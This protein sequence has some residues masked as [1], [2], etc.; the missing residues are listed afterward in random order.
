SGTEVKGFPTGAGPNGEIND[1][2]L[3]AAQLQPVIDDLISQGV[4]KIVLVSHL[5]QIGLEELLATKLVGVDVIISGGSNTRLG[6]ADDEAV[7][8]PGHSAEFEGEYPIVT[9]GADGK[10]TLIVNTDSEFTYLGRLV[11]DFDEN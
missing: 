7:A 9:A 1:M 8:F 4:N 3:L 5:Q 2:D 10:T 11:V 6:D